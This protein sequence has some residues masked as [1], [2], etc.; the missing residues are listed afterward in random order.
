MITEIK[1]DTELL[2]VYTAGRASL[3]EL[4]QN[5]LDILAAVIEHKRQ[6]VLFDGREIKG[7]FTET[8]RFDYASFIADQVAHSSEPL[9]TRTTRFAFVLHPA[10][11]GPQRFGETVALNRGM[12]LKA[13]EDREEALRWL[14][15][16]ATPSSQAAVHVLA[17]AI[18]T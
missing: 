7:K 12:N 11:L 18:S 17:P 4:K 5:F 14:G 8:A 10:A 16:S 3:E 15:V 9:I 1:V 6:K 2:S 13:F